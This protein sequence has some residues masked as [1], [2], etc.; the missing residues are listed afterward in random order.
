MKLLK[1][2]RCASP[3]IIATVNDH[4][5]SQMSIKAQSANGS[6]SPLALVYRTS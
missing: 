1:F 3:L 4:P 5:L 6:T 2:L